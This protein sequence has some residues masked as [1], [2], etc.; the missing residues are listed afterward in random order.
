VAG[1]GFSAGTLSLPL[2]LTSGQSANFNLQFSPTSAGAASGTASVISNDP[3]SPGV[4]ALSG[5]G[6][7]ATQ[8]L[9]FSSTNLAFGSVNVA[10]SSTKSVTVTNTGNS[11]VTISQ[12]QISGTGFSITGAG[13]PITLNSGQTLTFSVVFTPT[14]SGTDSGT[15][16]V[17]S[18]ASGSPAAI[19]LTGTGVQVTPHYVD[20]NWVASTST[21]AGYNI[22]RSTSSGSG[23]SKLNGS[24][25]S[26]LAYQDT[27]VQSGASYYYVV[28]A[29][30]ASND[31]SVESNQA[32]ANIP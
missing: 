8:S 26:G 27:T 25:I 23:F 1:S 15:V 3:N 24:L 10:S 22:Y 14:A 7:A 28:T 12:I 20:L 9:A 16:N 30:D 6:I 5:T 13:V 18:N 31:E 32:A 2:S 29:V 4:I 11:S 21:V 19:A 17:T